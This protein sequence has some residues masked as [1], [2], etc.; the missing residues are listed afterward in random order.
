[1]PALALEALLQQTEAI[2]SLPRMVAQV[3]QELQRD[4]PDAH[5]LID[6]IGAEPG[7]TAQVLKMANSPLWGLPRRIDSVAEAV[8]V[9]GMDALRSVVQAVALGACFRSVPGVDLELF[10]RY[11]VQ[12]AQICRPLARSLGLP[13]GSAWTAGLM[14]ASG[15]LVMHLGM[16]QEMAALD[17]HVAL[18]DLHRAAAQQ[19]RFGYSYAGVGAALAQRWHFPD[20]IVRALRHQLAPFE[21]DVHEPLAGV[22][23]LASWRARAQAMNLDREAMRATFPDAVTMLLGLSPDAVLD[24]DPQPWASAGALAAFLP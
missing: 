10:W 5:R 6:G 19:A 2:P 4:E 14:H 16:P 22:V 7:L 17:W 3:L 24:Q 13:P 8:T 21:G 18:F 1:M 12:A 20:R 15:E 9:L 23:H 11:S